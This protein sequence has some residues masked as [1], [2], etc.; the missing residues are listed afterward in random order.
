MIVKVPFADTVTSD[1]AEVSLARAILANRDLP[2][3]LLQARDIL[4][5]GL[6]AGSG[7][8]EVWIRDLNTFI[9]LALDAGNQA[10]IRQALL[11]FFHFQGADGNIVD[12]YIPADKASVNYK[13][14]ESKTMPQFKAHKNTVETDQ[15]SSLIQAITR[16]VRKTGD[17]AILAEPVN[18]VTVSDRMVQAMTFLL[19]HRYAKKY[20]LLWGATTAD[21]GDVQ[22]EHSW[23]VELDEN[24]HRSVDIYDNA[25][26]I[27]AIND[28]LELVKDD[29]G[30]T[31][32][33]EATRDRLKQNV[34]THL[35]DAPKHKFR[36]HLYL[37]GSPF[38]ADFDEDSIYYHGGTAA[39]IEA[40]LLTKEEILLALNDMI[41]NKHASGAASIGLTV[42]PPYPQ[43]FFQ[44]KG[45]GPYSYQNGGDW[46]WFGGR[47]IQQ[48]TVN[49]Y[50]KQAYEEIL[51]MVQRVIHNKGFFE[52]YTV[53]NEPKGSGTF[54]GSAGVLGRAIEMLLAW[55]E[56]H[57]PA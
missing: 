48:L 34:R 54:R 56:Q 45:M 51:P 15:E 29:P 49:G 24:S 16:Y 35:W 5:S 40:G 11:V 36:P 38:P 43:G 23:G 21:W 31:R 55:A 52:W 46:T 30:K 41:S 14:I 50:V 2:Q 26:F 19:E 6:N 39:A 28:Y 9:E 53:T 7:Y 10:A 3:V 20:G 44:N 22:P 42:Y 8:G 12:G 4:K 17:R 13:Y 25:M 27:I 37:E 18:G 47:M 57:D 33:W 32:T 1:S